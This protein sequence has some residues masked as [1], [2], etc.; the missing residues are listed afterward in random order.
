MCKHNLSIFEIGKKI[1]LVILDDGLGF[2]PTLWSARKRPALWSARRRPARRNRG[3]VPPSLGLLMMTKRAEAV[4]GSC[5]IESQ[6]G[7]GTRLVVEVAP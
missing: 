5:Q 3:S 2:E 4:G 6:P 1:R 7:R